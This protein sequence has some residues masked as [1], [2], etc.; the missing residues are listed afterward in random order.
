MGRGRKEE[1]RGG[2]IARVCFRVEEPQS[3]TIVWSLIVKWC[4]DDEG[5]W[6]M[7]GRYQCF[8]VGT[9]KW[10]LRTSFE[11]GFVAV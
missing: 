8:L 3:T 10:G 2:G 5:R 1:G 6:M 9:E 4:G 11:A 7:S